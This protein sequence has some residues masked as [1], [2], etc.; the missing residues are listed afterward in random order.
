MAFPFPTMS[1]A[2]DSANCST[3]P[4]CGP[5]RPFAQR[6]IVS[7]IERYRDSCGSTTSGSLAW[8]AVP[9]VPTMMVTTL[10]LN[11]ASSSRS[12][13]DKLFNAALDDA[14]APIPSGQRAQDDSTAGQIRSPIHGVLTTAPTL[15]M[16]TT[17]PWLAINK[18]ANAWM[19]RTTPQ[20]LVSWTRLA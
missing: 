15:L 8:N 17:R 4:P 20:M 18:S 10:T 16:F 14:Y 5:A 1:S 3:E 2:T 7:C 11:G 9:T 19:V 12:V 6:L 13:S